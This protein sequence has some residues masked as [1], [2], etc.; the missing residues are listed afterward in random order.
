ME[1]YISSRYVFKSRIQKVDSADTGVA[2]EALKMEALAKAAARID[3]LNDQLFELESA[4]ATSVMR[5][6]RIKHRTARL[7]V[8]T[9]NQHQLNTDDFKSVCNVKSRRTAAR[10]EMR[11]P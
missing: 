10:Q 11:G 9:H 6:A 1:F 3:A 7:V 5:L 4:A 2:R 8:H